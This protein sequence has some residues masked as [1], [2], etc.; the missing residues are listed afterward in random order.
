MPWRGA[1]RDAGSQAGRGRADEGPW[2]RLRTRLRGVS[3]G[4]R[5]P[6]ETGSCHPHP[7]RRPKGSR[8]VWAAPRRALEGVLHEP[9]EVHRTLAR[10]CPGRPDDRRPR[11]PAAHPARAP[12]EGAHGR[13]RGAR[14]QPHRPF[15]RLVCARARGHRRGRGAPAPRDGRRSGLRGPSPRARPRRG[16]AGRPEGWRQLRARRAPAH[17]PRDG[18]G[19]GQGRA[20]R[21][22]R[23]GPRAQ[24]RHQRRPQGP[25][26]PTAQA[27]RPATTPS[28]STPA[29]S[30]RRPARAAS[31]PSS[32]ATTRS[33]APC[34]S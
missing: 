29:T 25:H 9:R 33:G 34:R 8:R 6:C 18:Q 13:P 30:P 19:E 20:R 4:A 5:A 22:R 17:G 32:G 3:G 12:L 31:T 28:R 23:H 26:R 2:G 16:R 1:G 15:R 27:R 21:G 11:V 10:L 24:H 7:R 14:L